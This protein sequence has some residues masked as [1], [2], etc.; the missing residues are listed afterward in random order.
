MQVRHWLIALV[1]IASALPGLAQA[2][3][4]DPFIVVYRASG[5]TDDGSPAN[6]G[7]ATVVFCTNVS[8]VTENM[9]L[10][11]RKSDGTSVYYSGSIPLASTQTYTIATHGIEMFA[12]GAN[13]ATGAIQQGF[14]SIGS[15]TMNI[16]CSAMVVPANNT[17]P[18]GLPL[19]MQRYNP[20]PNTLD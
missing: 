11:F 15:T 6:N 5:V 3:T 16:F 20:A 17:L 7:T 18:A 14:L 4:S 19:H 2:A 1:A 13:A 12:L 10:I 8:S 9:A